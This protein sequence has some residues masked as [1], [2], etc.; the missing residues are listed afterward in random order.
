MKMAAHA[1]IETPLH[2]MM[3]ASD[4]SLIYFVQRFDRKA[5]KKFAVEDFGQ[6]AG[7]PKEAKYDFSMERLI[8]IIDHFCTFRAKDKEKLF[9]L[10]LFNFLAGNEEWMSKIFRFSAKMK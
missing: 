7:L 8:P 4:R 2:G 3:Y 5:K 1:K 9:R 6:L 10:T